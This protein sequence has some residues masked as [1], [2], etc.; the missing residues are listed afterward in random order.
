M[1]NH[2]ILATRDISHFSQP[3]W[4]ILPHS[5]L[6]RA[7]EKSTFLSNGTS[8]VNLALS[9]LVWPHLQ[10]YFLIHNS[11]GLSEATRDPHSSYLD[12]C[13][14]CLE[15]RHKAVLDKQMTIQCLRDH[16]FIINLTKSCLSPIYC[17]EHLRII[18]NAL[19]NQI[20]LPYYKA[21]KIRELPSF[22]I[23]ARFTSLMTLANLRNME[24]KQWEWLYPRLLQQFLS[25]SHSQIL[26]KKALTIRPPVCVKTSL[27]IHSFYANISDK[28]G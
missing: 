13:M 17:L 8:T 25:P 1:F 16:G 23:K 7:Q 20:L 14:I 22:V 24:T 21:Q 15:I 19:V 28:N 3:R 11:H 12:K 10:D 26:Q 9:Q 4:G 6:P 27:F 5:S 18:I 2:G